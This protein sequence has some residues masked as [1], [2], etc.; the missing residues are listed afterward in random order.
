MLQQSISSVVQAAIN[1]DRGV[2]LDIYIVAT[3]LERIGRLETTARAAGIAAA[4]LSRSTSRRSACSITAFEANALA[5]QVRSFGLEPRQITIECTEQQFVP[6]LAQLLRQVKALRRLG[7]G[8]AVD[9]AGA[10]YASFALIAALKPSVIKIDRDIVTGSTTT[11]PSRPSSRRSSRSAAGSG[12]TS[13]PKASNA[14]P[15]SP[16]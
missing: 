2:E 10:G 14:A 4:P 3:A 5:A 7:F 6:D 9:D 16:R 8:F 13:W 1:T 11:T 12:R 15:T